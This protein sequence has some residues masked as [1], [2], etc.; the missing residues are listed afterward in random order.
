MAVIA[1]MIQKLN[2]DDDDDDESNAGAFNVVVVLV[3]SH[4]PLLAM[5]GGRNQ[6]KNASSLFF[7]K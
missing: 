4:L 6:D 2:D 3:V 7:L 5:V 1:T